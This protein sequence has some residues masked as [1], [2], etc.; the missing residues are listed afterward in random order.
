METL[1]LVIGGIGLFLLGMHLMTDGLKSMAGNALKDLLRK[2]TGGTFSSILSG[3]FITALIQSSS[4]TTFMTIGFVSAGLLTF[5]QSIGV[6]IG[7]NVG[8]TSTGW[9][10]S[11]IGF[12]VNMTAIALPLIGIGVLL[13][14]LFKNKFEPHGL[15][16][17]GFGLLFLGIDVLQN[18][19]GNLPE[20]I[21]FN[22]L[23]G[24]QWWLTIVLVIVGIVMTVV[25]Q[26][27]SAAVVTT[28]TA[29]HTGA[30]DIHQAAVLVIG[31]N[32]GTTVKAFLAAIGGT[33]AAKRTATAH[34]LFNLL[35]GVVALIFL[36][37]LLFIVFQLTGVMGITDAAVTLA[38]FHTLFNII[39]VVVVVSILP[40]FK[41]MVKAII[42]D[43]EEH[44]HQYLDQ[45][46]ASVGPVAIEA[47][48]L[49]LTK[50]FTSVCN[51][52]Q[53]VLGEGQHT[54]DLAKEEKGLEE[55]QAFLSTIDKESLSTE[56]QYE[57]HLAVIHAID[58]TERLIRALKDAEQF[59]KGNG[60]HEKVTGLVKEMSDVLSVTMEKLHQNEWPEIERLTESHSLKMAELRRQD[61]Q[62]LFQS[63]IQEQTDIQGVI[64]IVQTIHWIDRLAYHLWRASHHLNTDK[65]VHAKDHDPVNF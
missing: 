35:T 2:F 6:I 25:L 54:S 52:A 12:Q 15:A 21:D 62:K 43:R 19:M 17:A 11:A 58:H 5:S 20:F 4:A 56:E 47:A 33:I 45:T 18:G 9:I 22:Y 49:T 37:G 32:V 16:L 1:G 46:V 7:A 60:H 8:S 61:R 28:L 38:I 44:F 29:L 39:G 14:F 55:I 36:N 65:E 26:S 24:D 30:I 3:T 31:Q 50:V 13:K 53:K 27:S 41:K 64:K 10:V 63:T 42:P 48:K 23:S 51:Q 34:I 57:E 40:L 59:L